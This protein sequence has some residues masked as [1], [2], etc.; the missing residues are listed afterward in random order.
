MG[1]PQTK[2]SVS[3]EGGKA[4]FLIFASSTQPVSAMYVGV[5]SQPAGG[6]SSGRLPTTWTSFSRPPDLAA[7]SS[8][9]SFIKMSVGL[10]LPY[11]TVTLRSSPG[12]PSS[13]H[14][15]WYIGVMPVPA[16]IMVMVFLPS[17]GYCDL[18]LNLMCLKP[19]LAPSSSSC[20]HCETAPPSYRLTSSSNFPSIELSDI[21]VYGR[22]ASVPSQ[23]SLPPPS[24]RPRPG[25]RK[26]RHAQT[27]RFRDCPSGR[28]KAYMVES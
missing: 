10:L 20:N 8:S 22:T 14:I 21:G 1:R 7:H 18:M 16:Q 12:V 15:A 26:R 17:N 4:Y 2:T 23:S 3:S 5:V 25:A 28:P 19:T 6:G 11:S 13:F 24:L 27:G 9:C